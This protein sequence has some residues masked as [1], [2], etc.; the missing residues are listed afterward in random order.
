[1][2]SLLGLTLRN[3]GVMR[4]FHFLGVIPGA[5]LNSNI[6]CR[7]ISATR[8]GLFELLEHYYSLRQI[9]ILRHIIEQFSILDN[10]IYVKSLSWIFMIYGGNLPR[11]IA[12]I[13]TRPSN[14]D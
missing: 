9:I 8:P 13:F 5:S 14:L 2:Q 1:M 6:Y 7:K 10:I 11:L 4:A 12:H 3:R